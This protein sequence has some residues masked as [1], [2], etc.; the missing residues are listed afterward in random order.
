VP[1]DA[2]IWLKSSLFLARHHIA[3]Y[4]GSSVRSCSSDVFTMQS[5]GTYYNGRDISTSCQLEITIMRIREG[6]E[7]DLDQISSARYL[8]YKKVG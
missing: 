1:L 5:T 4:E 7:M 3:K 2:V 6:I 8:A